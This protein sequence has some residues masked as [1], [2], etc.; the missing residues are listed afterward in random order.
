MDV[1]MLGTDGVEATRRIVDSGADCQVVM[2]TTFDLD[3]HILDALR[4]GA[5]GILLKDGPA[6]SLV[7]AVDLLVGRMVRPLRRR[8]RLRIEQRQQCLAGDT[9]LLGGPAEFV[10]PCGQL[11]DLL[12]RRPHT[13]PR[14]APDLTMSNVRKLGTR[15]PGALQ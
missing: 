5:V 10:Q 14:S 11:R 12:P 7:E 13:E 2:L 15:P 3:R 4:A 1:R 8:G 9:D 6:Q